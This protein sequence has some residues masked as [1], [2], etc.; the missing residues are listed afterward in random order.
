MSTR[1]NLVLPARPVSVTLLQWGRVAVFI[2]CLLS[3]SSSVWGQYTPPTTGLVGWW[4]GEGNAN[5]S[6]GGHNGTLLDGVGFDT[7]LF[8]QAFSFAGTA[9]R[10][11]IPDSPDFKLTN[12]LTISAWIFIKAN[13]W[14]VLERSG[15]QS[16]TSRYGLT[17]D[18]AGGMS[19]GIS[20]ATTGDSLTTPIEYNKWKQVT[21]TLDG[22][23]GEMRIY[24]DGA[25]AAQKTTTL[26]PAADI[27]PSQQP[28]IGIGNSPVSGGFPFIGLIDEVVL[29]LW[30][31]LWAKM[32]LRPVPESSS[33]WD[34][35]AHPAL[36]RAILSFSLWTMACRASDIALVEWLLHHRTGISG[37][38]CLENGA[39]LIPTAR[40]QPTNSAHEA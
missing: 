28:G 4:R 3:T 40:W 31:N 24:I 2:C 15:G 18:D 23:T 1:T 37:R 13:C 5:D 22:A 32:A 39:V 12:S 7:G 11:Y 26:R 9:N 25:V 8:G 21:A 36:A 29:G 35:L 10:V 17:V 6:A 14:H 19:F 38:F 27:D 34:E 16:G 30:Q 20:T 33:D